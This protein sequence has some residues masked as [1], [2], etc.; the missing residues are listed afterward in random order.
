MS[1]HANITAALHLV[2]A[3]MPRVWAQRPDVSVW[4]VGKDPPAAVQALATH[5]GNGP[6]SK[7]VVV[8][9]T[10]PD[11]R[12]YL[13]QATV[14]VAPIPYG[15]GIQNKVLEAMS[16]GAPIIATPQASSAL[17]VRPDR[18]LVLAEDADD[19]AQAILQL[20]AQPQRRAALGANGRCYVETYHSWETAAR[21]FEDLYQTAICHT[22]LSHFR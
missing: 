2:K 4:I 9:G 6:A 16:C 10:V 3:I 21:S 7:R 12:P 17:Q 20:L 11:V 1:Y 5:D 19:F 15:A 22:S 13:Q 18:D 8:T 14:A